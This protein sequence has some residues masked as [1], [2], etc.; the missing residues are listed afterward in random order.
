M[1]T[2]RANYLRLPL[3]IF[4]TALLLVTVKNPLFAQPP[5]YIVPNYIAQYADQAVEQMLIYKIP[6]SVILAQAILESRGG[7]S[8][9]AIRSN[10]HFGIKCHSQ[11]IGDTI[12]KDDDNTNECFRKYKNIDESYTDHSIFLIS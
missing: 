6:A 1:V 3:L 4:Y 5:R 11:W 9:L 10:N 2:L 8:E 12:V 7:T